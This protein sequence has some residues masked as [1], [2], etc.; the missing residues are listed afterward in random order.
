MTNY[1]SQ[2][3]TEE[4]MN[5][6]ET[7]NEKFTDSERYKKFPPG[8]KQVYDRIKS[9]EFFPDFLGDENSIF[10][11]LEF[12]GEYAGDEPIDYEMTFREWISKSPREFNSRYLMHFPFDVNCI[13]GKKDYRKFK[14]CLVRL[15]LDSVEDWTTDEVNK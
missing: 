14:E 4:P 3:F 12:Y 7:V 13:R 9:F 1:R 2:K 8:V 10:V 15:D 6:I 11:T 5:N